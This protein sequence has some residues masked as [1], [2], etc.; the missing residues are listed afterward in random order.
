MFRL[1][2][3]TALGG[4]YWLVVIWLVLVGLANSPTFGGG[5]LVAISATVFF[6]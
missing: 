4:G 3:F 6:G 2:G 5:W 1:V